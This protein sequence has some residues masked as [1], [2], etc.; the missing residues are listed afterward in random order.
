MNRVSLMKNLNGSSKLILKAFEVGAD[1][2]GTQGWAANEDF[3]NAET[4][5]SPQQL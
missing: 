4:W 2:E 1:S 3:P 5:S